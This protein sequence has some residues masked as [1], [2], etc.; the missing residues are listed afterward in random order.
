VPQLHFLFAPATLAKSW[1][2]GTNRHL[3]PSGLPCPSPDTGAFHCSG[4]FQAQVPP[5][6]HA[7]LVQMTS[8]ASAGA[9]D[10]WPDAVHS[11]QSTVC[12][13]LHRTLH[14]FHHERRHFQCS[15]RRERGSATGAFA[16]PWTRGGALDPLF[17]RPSPHAHDGHRGV[18]GTRVAS[19]GL[20][21]DSDR[22]TL[23][24][25]QALLRGAT[26]EASVLRGEHR[27]WQ[28]RH[29]SGRC[30][31]TRSS[32]PRPSPATEAFASATYIFFST[33]FLTVSSGCCQKVLTMC[34]ACLVPSPA[35]HPL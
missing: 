19:T 11:V 2:G 25:G 18:W 12:N 20:A 14:L 22:G 1:L 33:T 15:H 29:R 31:T 35:G 10:L 4:R 34:E 6:G 3:A 26:P 7:L 32:C 21:R 5:C 28:R 8:N 24:R 30:G 13:S 27:V 9:A 23:P 17:S 16:V